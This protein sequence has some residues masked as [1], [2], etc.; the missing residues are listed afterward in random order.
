MGAEEKMKDKEKFKYRFILNTG[1]VIYADSL[2]ELEDILQTGVVISKTENLT[3]IEDM[4]M[5][6]FEKGNLSFKYWKFYW[7]VM[8]G[9]TIIFLFSF[10]GVIYLILK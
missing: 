8:V 6:G 4:Q 7:V 1:Q 2:S 3:E 10:F 9:L 5:T